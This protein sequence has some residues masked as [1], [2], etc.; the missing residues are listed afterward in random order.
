MSSPID[1][2][3]LMP[4]HRIQ[5]SLAV[6]KNAV[7]AAEELGLDTLPLHWEELM[8]LGWRIE[9]TTCNCGGHWAWIKRYDTMHGCVCHQTPSLQI[10][11]EPIYRFGETVGF[12]CSLCGFKF[13]LNVKGSDLCP[14]CGNR[15]FS[16]RRQSSPELED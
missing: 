11:L 10:F 13:D 14:N 9:L 16:T 4:M 12:H 5:P 1:P 2:F 6:W 8:R 7:R 15:L 3:K